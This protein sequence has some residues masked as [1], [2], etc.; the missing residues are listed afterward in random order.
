M[1]VG[2]T[3]NGVDYDLIRGGTAILWE[4]PARVSDWI[5]SYRWR[6]YLLNVHKQARGVRKEQFARYLCRTWNA[7]HDLDE[8][9]AKVRIFYVSSGPCRTGRS[10]PPNASSSIHISAKPFD[11]PRWHSLQVR[12]GVPI[13]ER[14]LAARAEAKDVAMLDLRGQGPRR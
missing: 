1:I 2:T 3:A 14:S 4:K 6:C 7:T 11:D 12:T 13:E 9:I 5:A 8:Q 10:L